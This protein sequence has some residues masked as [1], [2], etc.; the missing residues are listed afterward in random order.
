L[1]AEAAAIDGT[2]FGPIFGMA[3]ATLP[4]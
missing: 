1:M 2:A 3:S 4:A